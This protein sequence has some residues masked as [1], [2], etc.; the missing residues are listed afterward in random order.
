VAARLDDEET[1]RGGVTLARQNFRCVVDPALA[2]PAKRPDCVH[3]TLR[4]SL[5]AFDKHAIEKETN[6]K[7]HSERNQ[8]SF[9]DHVTDG[10]E[11]AAAVVVAEA[12]VD[13][14]RVQISN[15][16]PPEDDVL[17]LSLVPPKSWKYLFPIDLPNSTY[18]SFVVVFATQPNP[19]N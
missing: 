17:L 19:T 3:E 15:L 2:V 16:F 13:D 6:S 8:P 5:P 7:D 10:V 18:W 12:A 14:T 1:V 11:M 9:A 4:Q